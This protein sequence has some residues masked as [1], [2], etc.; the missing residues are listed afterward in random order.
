VKDCLNASH[1]QGVIVTYLVAIIPLF[2]RMIQCYKAAKQQ[3]GKFIGHLQMWNFFK[4][5]SSV[6]TATLSF[7][8]TI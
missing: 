5:M 8:S 6:I 3:S 2:I 7:L 1:I 4:Y